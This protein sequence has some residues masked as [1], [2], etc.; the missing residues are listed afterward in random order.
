MKNRAIAIALLACAMTGTAAAQVRAPTQTTAS[1]DFQPV[2]PDPVIVRLNE[3][4]KELDA[5]KETA[6]KQVVVLH[7]SPAEDPGAEENNYNNNQA[8]ATQACQ[9]VL[10]DRFGRMLAYRVW[11]HDD[12]YYLS[13]ISCE[14]K[15]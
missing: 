7:F 10:G 12:R 8:K 2:K 5:L 13:H 14:T 1:R 3:L 15:L 9:Q 6:G 11:V 4:Q